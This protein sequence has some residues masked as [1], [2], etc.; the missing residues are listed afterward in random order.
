MKTIEVTIKQHESNVNI[1]KQIINVDHIVRVYTWKT[2]D[3]HFAA[4]KLA[5]NEELTVTESYEDIANMLRKI[6]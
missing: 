2:N 4:L 3:G 1:P 6:K 5:N